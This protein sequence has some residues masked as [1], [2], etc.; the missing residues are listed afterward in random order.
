[1]EPGVLGLDVGTSSVKALLFDRTG[2]IRGEARVAYPLSTPRP[3]WVEQDPETLWQ[4]LLRAIREVVAR[5]P[6]LRV[7]GLA[8]AAQSGSLLL[9][10][11]TGRPLAP[12][13]TWM[14]GRSR[15]VVARWRAQGREATI[16]AV[17]GW[18]LHPGLGLPTLAWLGEERPE[19]L[20]RARRILSVND[21][22]VHRLT[23]RFV[24]NPSNA[25]GLQLLDVAAGEW[26]PE[27]CALAGVSPAQLAPV[28]P[29]GEAIGPLLPETA[30]A[31]GLP[32]DAVVVN[33]GHDQA[34]TALALGITEPGRFLLACGTAWVLTGITGR[35]DPPGLPPT[36]DVS[37][38]VLPQRWTISR[39]LGGLGASLAWWVDQAWQ[40]VDPSHPPSREARFAGLDR[41]LAA[42]QPGSRGLLFLPMTGGHG[43]PSTTRAGGF[44]GLGLEHSRGEMARA[45]LESGAYE[46]AWALEPVQAAGLPVEALWM[47]GGGAR[48]ALWP[49]ILA[50]VTGLPIH[51]P[52]GEHW[53]ALGAALLA[54]LGSGLLPNLEQGLAR[55]LGSVRTVSPDRE[56]VQAYR[57]L[58]VRYREAVRKWTGED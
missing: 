38:H 12:F 9:A 13:I 57:K 3:G 1:M 31:T 21:F 49:A 43:D 14:D 54:G 50:D 48:S 7:Q 20:G 45:I 27:L 26:S 8:L 22:L 39:S 4:A 18:S 32:A 52:Q 16:R 29:S 51:L 44:L 24:T 42:T 10:D 46:L 11:R 53:P 25:A 15:E 58:F 56:R 40:G 5:V 33:G 41:E 37:R 55:S 34:C 2:A 47:V 6:G 19:L 35:P 17:S 30:Q 23:G 36:L 28:E